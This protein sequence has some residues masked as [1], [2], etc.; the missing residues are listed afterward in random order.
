MVLLAAV[1]L[2][3]VGPGDRTEVLRR[4][5]AKLG[6]PSVPSRALNQVRPLARA[7]R[8][9][10]I[11]LVGGRIRIRQLRHSLI[12]LG[13]RGSPVLDAGGSPWHGTIRL[14]QEHGI[15]F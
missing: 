6:V 11:A 15:G 4:R 8:E 5:A 3:R 12:M 13:L 14:D 9:L 2:R 10:H 1:I 7:G